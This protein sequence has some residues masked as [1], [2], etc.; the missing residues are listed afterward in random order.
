MAD[1]ERAIWRGELV[2]VTERTATGVKIR[3]GFG[4]E[5]SVRKRDVKPLA[6]DDERRTFRVP[7]GTE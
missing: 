2:T 7:Q 1:R 4:Y 5:H 6:K 3:D